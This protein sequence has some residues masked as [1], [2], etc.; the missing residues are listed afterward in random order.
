MARDASLQVFRKQILRQSSVAL[1]VSPIQWGAPEW[2]SPVPGRRWR[3]P[4][5]V[6]R[7]VTE[8]AWPVRGGCGAWRCSSWRP[9]AHRGRRRA[10]PSR[11]SRPCHSGVNNSSPVGKNKGQQ[12][13]ML[14]VCRPSCRPG[15][16]FLNA[17][18][19]SNGLSAMFL[20]LHHLTSPKTAL[21]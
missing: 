3:A 8:E 13:F 1:R 7:A 20:F 2:R 18:K 9:S 6:P 16:L 15:A 5:P 21:F 14:R 11:R 19:T 12:Q 10:D 4:G 17:W